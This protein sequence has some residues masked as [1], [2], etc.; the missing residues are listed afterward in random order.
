MRF[1]TKRDTC[2]QGLNVAYSTIM[3]LQTNIKFGSYLLNLA[4]R[5]VTQQND[6]YRACSITANIP[7]FMIFL[8]INSIYSMQVT[9]RI[10]KY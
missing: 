8:I 6:P 9:A 3:V 10:N 1:Q 4:L 5:S 2:G 7:R